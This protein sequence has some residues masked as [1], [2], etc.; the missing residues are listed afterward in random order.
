MTTRIGWIGK[1]SHFLHANLLWL[2]LGSY[3]VAAVWSGPG[4][5]LRAASFGRVGIAGA[6][7]R[8]SIPLVMLSLL[9]FNAGLGVPLDRLRG[10]ARRPATLLLGLAANLV[11]PMAFILGVSVVLRGWHNNDEVQNI[12]L[13][14]ALVAA[15]PIAGSSTAWS[16]NADGDLALS[17]GLVLGS[18]LIS[19]LTTPLALRA[20]GGMAQGGY[21]DALL[22]LASGGAGAFLLV[23]VIAPTVLGAAVR[24]AAG[25]RRLDGL[26]PSLKLA[27]MVMLLALNYANASASLPQAIAHPDYD[28]LTVTLVIA[29]GLCVT[30]F[31]AG[32]GI[33]RLLGAAHEQRTALMFGLGMNN[34]GTG[35]VMASLALG[36]YPR[37][38]LPI[39][40]YNLAQHLVAGA[41]DRLICRPVP[42]TPAAGVPR[43]SEGAAAHSV[44]HTFTPATE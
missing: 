23:G 43:A 17:L 14:L 3:A 35:L 1:T 34:N 8:L 22:G 25:T 44:A 10:L 29:V 18:T 38:M 32:W 12:L 39:I 28:F 16:Q 2:L 36:R 19:P 27:N 26:K 15:M 20:V 37:V 13:G 4:M 11:V 33:A 24:C 30:A 5:A 40:F 41:A 21:A 6:H 7:V 9:L 31:T 42:R